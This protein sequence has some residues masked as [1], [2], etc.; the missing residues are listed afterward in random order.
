MSVT[1]SEVTTKRGFEPL[2]RCSALATTRRV[3]LQLS[4]V[5]QA[6]SAKRRA[7]RILGPALSRGLGE[8]FGDRADQA[9][10]AGEAEEI[11]DPMVLAPGHEL[12]PGKAEIRPQQDLD[13]GPVRPDLAEDALELIEGPG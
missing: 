2:G 10:V 11:I 9:L 12:V 1:L 8:L 13:P 3:R 4:S 7:G 5:R 6:K